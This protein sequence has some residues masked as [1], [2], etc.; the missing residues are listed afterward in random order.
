MSV[1]PKFEF[2]TVEGGNFRKPLAHPVIP[3]TP[4]MRRSCCG[5]LSL[6]AK[7]T[8]V[9]RYAMLCCAMLCCAA[10]CAHAQSDD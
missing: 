10:L 4:A 8:V 3:D 6:A 9:L 2:D 7:S 5:R 1:K